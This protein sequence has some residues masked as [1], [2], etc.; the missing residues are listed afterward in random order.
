M[1]LNLNTLPTQGILHA[2]FHSIWT[3]FWPDKIDLVFKFV[4]R[5]IRKFSYENLTFFLDKL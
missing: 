5:K 4:N 2:E 1:A 3:T